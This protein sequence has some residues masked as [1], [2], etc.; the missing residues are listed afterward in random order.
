MVIMAANGAQVLT[1]A[2][3]AAQVATVKKAGRDSILLYIALPHGQNRFIAI[4]LKTGK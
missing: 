2:Q 4:K 3:L 1:P